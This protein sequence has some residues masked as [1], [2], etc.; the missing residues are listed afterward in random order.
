MRVGAIQHASD[1]FTTG[2]ADM[3]LERTWRCLA[4]PI[5]RLVDVQGGAGGA[6]RIVVVR[7]GRA[8]KRHHGVTDMLVDRTAVAD[9]NP[10]NER[11]VT[12]H[13]LVNLFRIERLRHCG[14]S[15]K[16][17]EEYGDL[18]AL[19]CRKAFGRRHAPRRCHTPL[20]DCRQQSLA[21][22]ERADA[23]FF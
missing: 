12:S 21:M 3:R 14:E 20:G 19:A 10:V 22:A 23:E 13:Q 16:I 18:T 4:H 7:A 17:G 9:N 8:K 15:A 1:H 2:N 6:H 11:R 5:E